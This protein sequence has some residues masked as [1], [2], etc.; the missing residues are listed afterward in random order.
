ME[1]ITLGNV[2]I[3]RVWEYYGSV[4]MTPDAF[5]P[6][7]S[8]EVWESGTDW[9]APHF[10]DSETNIVNSAIQTWLLRSEGRTI[11]VDTGVGNHKERPYAP[12]WS[13]RETDFLANLA[14]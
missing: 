13:H 14:R 10:L 5:F 9:L 4:E 1:Q 3:T 2:S 6:E 8:K 7:S 11:L 12:V